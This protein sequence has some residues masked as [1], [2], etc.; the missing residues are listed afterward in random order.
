M[1]QLQQLT[2]AIQM[3]NQL[4]SQQPQPET[5]EDILASVIEP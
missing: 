3:N 2:G 4:N 5:A 1:Q